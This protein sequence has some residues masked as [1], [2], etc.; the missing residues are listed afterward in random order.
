MLATT[1]LYISSYIFCG[2]FTAILVRD[3]LKKNKYYM[4]VWNYV[5]SI[6]FWPIFYLAAVMWYFIIK[7]L[8]AFVDVLAACGTILN[9]KK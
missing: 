5:G 4:G 8:N 3:R 9:G 7:P 1:I 6:M 2:V